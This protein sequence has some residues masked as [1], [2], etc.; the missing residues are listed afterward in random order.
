M[1]TT[2][3]YQREETMTKLIEALQD[4]TAEFK[5]ENDAAELRQMERAR[6]DPWQA[7]ADLCWGENDE[8]GILSG[9]F[10]EALK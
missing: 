2:A 1:R 7:L 3:Y 4:L 9:N 5:A 10:K 6:K 8:G